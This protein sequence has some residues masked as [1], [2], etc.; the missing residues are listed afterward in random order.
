MKRLSLLVIL[1]LLLTLVMGVT[2][3]EVSAQ[4]EPQIT[5]SP[6][7]GISTITV[8]GSGFVGYITVYWDNE[9]IPTVPYE[10]IAEGSAGLFSVIITVPTQTEPSEHTVSAKD[11][12]EGTASATFTVIDLTGKRGS[13]GKKGPRGDLGSQGPIGEQG[14][15]GVQ[16]PP[17]PM[18]EQGPTGVPGEA[19]Q[20]VFL[21]PLVISIAAVILGLIL[22]GLRLWR[23]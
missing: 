11:N 3:H 1:T 14:P 12:F 17:G 5:L 4:T 20:N 7:E 8:T 16:G 22:L 10:V 13:T 23:S 9:E 6:T 2:V 19:G 15:P 18:G 21:A